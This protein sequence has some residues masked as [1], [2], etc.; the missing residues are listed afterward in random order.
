MQKNDKQ[1]KPAQEERKA[2][3]ALDLDDLNKVQGGS[4]ANVS[5]T[6]TSD[7]SGDTRSKI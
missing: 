6:S 1:E 7:I 4:I 2:P 5:Y 3:Q